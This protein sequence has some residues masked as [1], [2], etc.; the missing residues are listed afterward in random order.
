MSTRDER[1]RIC[2]G[3]HEPADHVLAWVA[4]HACPMPAVPSI[5]GALFWPFTPAVPGAWHAMLAGWIED[6]SRAMAHFVESLQGSLRPDL[7]GA[8]ASDLFDAL[9]I[10]ELYRDLVERSGWSPDEYERWLARTLAWQLLGQA[11]P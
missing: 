7:D 11:T 9:T 2:G 4:D 5:L 10:P 6:K 8:R 3:D 1:N